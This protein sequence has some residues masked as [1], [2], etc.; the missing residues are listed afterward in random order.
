LAALDKLR[1]GVHQ[2]LVEGI[3]LLMGFDDGPQHFDR[4]VLVHSENGD[5]DAIGITAS[6]QRFTVS[7]MLPAILD[8][9]AQEPLIRRHP[10]V[11]RLIDSFLVDTGDFCIAGRVHSRVDHHELWDFHSEKERKE[12]G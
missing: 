2:C 3:V 12:D 7:A 10:A 9:K 11:G 6:W 1:E 4:L 5:S 8:H